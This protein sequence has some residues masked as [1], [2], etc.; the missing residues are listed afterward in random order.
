VKLYNVII[1][2]DTYVVAGD[3][4]AAIENAQ[5]AVLD[6]VRASEIGPTYCAALPVANTPVQRR[7]QAERPIVASDVS[8][9]DFAKLKG[10]TTQ[11]V[12]DFL[13]KKAR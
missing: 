8:D 13:T 10:K 1:T 7:C 2:V 5:Q 9:V 6:M 12:H 3:D 11:D 4:D